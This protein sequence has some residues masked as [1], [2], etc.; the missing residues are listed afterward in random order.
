MAH[1][2]QFPASSTFFF[3]AVLG[4]HQEFETLDSRLLCSLFDVVVVVLLQFVEKF[5]LRSFASLG[6]I[7][8]AIFCSNCILLHAAGQELDGSSQF[9]AAR[10]VVDLVGNRPECAGAKT[11]LNLSESGQ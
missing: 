11:G 2:I 7:N 4:Y 3:T 5:S 10:G 1:P 9:D 6:T 8:V